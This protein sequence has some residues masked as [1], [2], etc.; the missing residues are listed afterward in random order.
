LSDFVVEKAKVGAWGSYQNKIHSNHDSTSSAS[1]NTT[2]YISHGVNCAG[3]EVLRALY[4]AKIGKRNEAAE[5]RWS[6]SA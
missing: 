4:D 1:E 3:S 6:R 2:Q 5:L